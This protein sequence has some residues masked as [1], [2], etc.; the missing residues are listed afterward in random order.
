MALVAERPATAAAPAAPRP[1]RRAR[2]RPRRRADAGAVQP[3][4]DLDQDSDL[5]P[6]RVGRRR[7]PLGVGGVVDGDDQAAD[8]RR[9]APARRPC[10]R[11]DDLVGDEDVRRSRASI[12]AVASQT[13]AVV[14]PIAPASICIC[15]RIGLLWIFACGRS[16]AGTVSIRRRISSMLARDLRQ[17][18][19]QRRRRQLLERGADEPAGRAVGA[20]SL[21]ASPPRREDVAGAEVAARGAERC[22]TCRRDLDRRRVDLGADV[23]RDRAAG[24][25]PAAG[26]DRVGRRASRSGPPACGPGCRRAGGGPRAAPGCRG[27]G[28]SAKTS[29][30]APV[31]TIRPRYMIAT[32]SARREITAS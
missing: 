8:R 13:V 30:V 2:P 1:A 21:I 24:V 16:A 10:G 32:R 27:G 29:A 20:G 28:G 11:A 22:P 5:A 31:S 14:S 17:V 18:E 25:E 19:D 6:G 7:D 26:R 15:P 23:L 9:A 12:I 4:V 3:D